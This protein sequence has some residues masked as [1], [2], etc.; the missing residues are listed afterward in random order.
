MSSAKNHMRRS[1]RSEPAHRFCVQ[2]MQKFSPEERGGAPLPS[3]C[4]NREAQDGAQQGAQEDRRG[5]V[6]R[7][8]W[9]RRCVHVS[10]QTVRAGEL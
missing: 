6:S 2:Q 10:V 9:E 3:L 8:A 5:A 7:T 1:H 4:K